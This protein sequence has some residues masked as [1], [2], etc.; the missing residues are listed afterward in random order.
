MTRD[1]T[2]LAL[3][4]VLSVPAPVAPAPSTGA[5]DVAVPEAAVSPND[6]LARAILQD[7]NLTAALDRA[8]TLL[9]TGVNAGSSYREVWIRD[10]NTFIELSLQVADPPAIRQALL[11]FFAF[12]GPDGDIADAYVLKTLAGGGYSY[13]VSPLAP[14]YAAFKNTVA[15]DQESSLIQ[16]IRKYVTATGDRAILDERIDGRTVRERLDWALDYLVNQRFD[17]GYGLLWGATTADWG[18]VQPEHEWGVLLDASSH[19]AIDIYDN[20]M[21]LIALEDLLSLPGFEPVAP[22]WRKVRDDVRVNARRHLWDAGRKRF[23]PHIYL[24]GSPFPPTFNEAAVFVHGG[25]AVA[26]EAGLLSRDEVA[27]SLRQMRDNVERAG[28][29]SIGLTQYPPYPTGSFKNPS[30]APYSYQNGGDWCW[31]GGRM[32]Q[33][34]IA[35]GLVDQAYRELQP[36]VNRVLAYGVFSEWWTRTNQPRG[37][38]EFRG[39]AGVLGLAIQQL[40]DWA[41]LESREIPATDADGDTLDGGWEERMG[42]NAASAVGND[43][44]DGDPDG[45]GVSNREEWRRGTHPRGDPAAT[46]FLAEGATIAPFAERITLANP[47]GAPAHVLLRFLRTDGRTVVDARVIPPEAS[48]IVDTQH[49]AGLEAAEFS[50]AVES[51]ATV[52]VSRLMT[53]DRSGYGSHMETATP[54]ARLL[55]YLAEGATHAWFDLF[56]LLHNPNDAAALVEVTYLRPAPA[57]PVVRAYVVNPN[58][59]R[60]IWVDAEPGLGNTDVSAIIR[61]T[62]GQPIVVERSM[63]ATSAGRLFRAGHASMAIPA[64][65]PEWFLAEGATGDFFDLFVLVANPNSQAAEVQVDFLLTD[66]STLT[67]RYAI[68]GQSRFNIW[69][70]TV[71]PRLANAAVSTI[72]KSL[73]GMPVVVERAMWWPGPTAATWEEAHSSAGAVAAGTRWGTAGGQCGGDNGSETFILIANTSATWGQARVR[74]LFETG[75]P[76]DRLYD[77]PPTS[78]TNVPIC[79]QEPAGGFGARAAGRRFGA[80]VESLGTIPA[81]LVVEHSLYSNAGQVFW[82]AG[83]NALATRLP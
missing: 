75:P 79:A 12:Q 73:N 60:T 68:A 7:P 48:L 8:R 57:V 3:G 53:W 26:I 47:N 9:R 16:A 83:A 80:V 36:M 5:R 4:F 25:T 54:S 21:F 15:T 24:R 6:A 46:R 43:G 34:L 70:D 42:L 40:R 31:F 64:P 32:V 65:A 71:D 35:Y 37:A 66:G 13:R 51:D 78:R 10:L 20:A 69:V 62:N 82:A 14:D 18:D 41:A 33:Q 19:R 72:V 56:Y 81:A 59:R 1:V 61:V 30:L 77:L 67:R 23:V 38:G 29:Y 49:R 63:Y 50:T 39:S 17:P 22:R 52:V 28:A 58:S 2:V 45:D 27:E 44:A 74:L 76:T 55:W 11:R